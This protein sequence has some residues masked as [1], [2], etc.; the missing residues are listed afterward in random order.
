MTYKKRAGRTAS[1]V[2]ALSLVIEPSAHLLAAMNQGQPPTKPATP[3]A[4]RPRRRPN[5]LPN[6]RLPLPPRR[7]SMVAGRVSTT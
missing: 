1:I 7:Q 4:T 6:R 3:P 2:V 5:P